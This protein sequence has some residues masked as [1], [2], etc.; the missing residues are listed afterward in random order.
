MNILDN[1]KLIVAAAMAFSIPS[2]VDATETGTHFYGVFVGAKVLGKASCNVV[3]GEGI[4]TTRYGKAANF[5]DNPLANFYAETALLLVEDVEK[6]ATKKG[7]NA[8]INLHLD[9][10]Q[11]TDFVTE[12]GSSWKRGGKAFDAEGVVVGFAAGDMIEIHCD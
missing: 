9:I 7:F 5:L 4:F 8:V 2:S 1:F 11:S 3:R 10:E 6:E 12:S